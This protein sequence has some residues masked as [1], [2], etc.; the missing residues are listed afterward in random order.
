[1]ALADKGL[2]EEA[3]AEY[4]HAIEIDPTIV[5]AHNNL[6]HLLV[7]RSGITAVQEETRR[8]LDRLPPD[9]PLRKTAA[10]QLQD[11]ERLLALEHRLPAILKGDEKPAN[12]QEQLDLAQ[13]CVDTKRYAGA[14]RFFSGAFADKPELA[15]DQPSLDRYDAACCAALAGCGQGVDADKL[16]ATER[17]RL[18]RLA[19]DWLRDEL[20]AF[21]QML[22]RSLDK[23]APRVAGGL[24]RCLVEPD[25][26]SVR[27]P[28]ALARLPETER[29][30]WQK[31][32][33]DVADTLTRARE[34]SA[35]G[36]KPDGK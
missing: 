2:L 7:E 36:K 35:A 13:L 28:E 19:L 33:Q 16:D 14:A 21:R 5:A 31:L 9:H 26:A 8:W 15:G 23:A 30:D 10:K 18:R 34:I 27:G 12:T 29:P 25:F 17:V 11:C 6:C 22:D 24:Q 1:M 32:W 3:I 20:K 4:R